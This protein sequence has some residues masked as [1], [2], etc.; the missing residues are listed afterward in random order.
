MSKCPGTFPFPFPFPFSSV[1]SRFFLLLLK[2]RFSFLP[3]LL[4]LN[5]SLL[6]YQQR[7][8][9]EGER[10]SDTFEKDGDELFILL[11]EISVFSC[12]GVKN[13]LKLTEEDVQI[14]N[15]KGNKVYFIRAP[16]NYSISFKRI[17]VLNN[18]A[19]LSGELGITL[20]VPILEGPAGIRFDV[21]YT[22][23]PETGL[24]NQQCDEFSGIVERD[25]RQYC[26]Y[27][28]LCGLTDQLEN[29]LT[30]TDSDGHRFL[31]ALAAGE[32][33]PFSPRCEKIDAR[34][35]EFRRTI[36]LP[37]RRELEQKARQKIS[38]VD[39]EIRKRLNKGRGRFQVFLNLISADQPPITQ[40]AWFDGS[41]QCRCCGR[42]KDPNCR[43]VLSFLYCN[44]EDC[45]SAYAQQ[46]LHNS[47]R[48]VACYTVEFNYRMTTRRDEVQMFLRENN[49]PDQDAPGTAPPS[50]PTISA[51]D[52][53]SS[54]QSA[55]PPRL[56]VI[57]D[58]QRA[59]QPKELSTRCV[60]QM[61]TRLTHLRRYC[62][63]FWNEKLCC[64][65]CPGIC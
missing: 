63:I 33:A 58:E 24:L 14:V 26:R 29:R 30:R 1:P 37:G 2:F 27:C 31:P 65:H 60:S 61:E 45:K 44:V 15:E 10:H 6:T 56:N 57:G 7:T 36:N 12:R 50:P 46:C 39:A 59:R 47:A 20:Q 52:A 55:A 13:E 48:I 53:S 35:Y 18:L 3:L 28:D 54:Q 19:H 62:T 49:Y 32:E 11:D 38:G 42:D 23:V 5:H 9:E 34:T 8:E 64:S 4:L 41:E 40:K 43:S 21:P 17:N 16:G 25:K 22:M 51:N